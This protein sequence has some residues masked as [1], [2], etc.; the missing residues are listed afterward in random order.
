MRRPNILVVLA[1]QLRRDALASFGDPD[2]S[3]PN[4][5]ALAARGVSFTNAS[6]TCPVCVPF[7]FTLLTGEYAHSRYVPS[8]DWRMSPAERMLADEFNEAGYRTCYVGKW[9]LYGAYGVRPGISSRDA[10]LHAIP[11]EHQGRF[12]RWLGFELSNAPFDTRYFADDDL[13]PRK[14]EGYQTD[15]LFDLAMGLIREEKERHQPFFLMLSVEPPHPPYEAPEPYLSR[16]AGRELTLPPNF[17]ASDEA[18]HAVLLGERRRYAAAVENL[19]WNVGRLSWFLT[20]QGIAEETVVVFLSDHGEL[21]GA[22]GLREK[23]WPYE[24]SVGIPLIISDPAHPGRHGTTVKDPVSTE[25]FLPTLLGLAGLKARD[26]KSGL[27]LSPLVRGEKE[28]LGREAILLEFIAEFRTGMPFHAE[29]WRAIRTNRHKYTVLG[30]GD[31]GS[32]WQLFDLA[33]DPYETRN[34][35]QDADGSALRREL[36]GLLG[37]VLKASGDH[38]RLKSF[39]DRR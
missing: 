3:T 20:E 1:D 29:T 25:D 34:L 13:E 4:L 39:G 24:E 22:H 15:G 33:E 8:I 9:H 6:S 2:I 32:S 17:R 16:W 36:H 26:S 38:Y 14:L 23:Q 5:D 35:V 31:A 19:D 18:E 11:P 7:R 27:D 28:G 12:A 30:A 21:G 10:N 37:D